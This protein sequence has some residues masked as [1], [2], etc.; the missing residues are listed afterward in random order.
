MRLLVT[1]IGHS[2]LVHKAY[3]EFA[4]DLGLRRPTPEI[5]LYKFADPLFFCLFC[6]HGK[7]PVGMIWGKVHP[8][9]AEKICE[10]EGFFVRR[11]FRGKMKFVRGLLEGAR[12]HIK[13]MGFETVSYTRL[14]TD[15]KLLRERSL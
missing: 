4:Q 12:E 11:G 3:S 8:Y 7:K 1:D 5:W 6:K 15:K 2:G 14:K 10:I 13:S 9:Y